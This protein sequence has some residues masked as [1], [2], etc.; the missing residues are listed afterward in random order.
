L[1]PVVVIEIRMSLENE[2]KCSNFLIFKKLEE[3]ASYSELLRKIAVDESP[4][5]VGQMDENGIAVPAV[6]EINL[7]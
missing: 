2:I 6:K 1:H 5:V 7:Y 4:S 3:P